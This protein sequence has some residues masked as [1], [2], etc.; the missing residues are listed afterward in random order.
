MSSV[1]FG[2]RGVYFCI[3]VFGHGSLL[4]AILFI[5]L[6]RAAMDVLWNTVHKLN[7]TATTKSELQNCSP[8]NKIQP[9]EIHEGWTK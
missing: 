9:P 6:G 8:R 5:C 1:W 3:V 2:H 4:V 7:Y